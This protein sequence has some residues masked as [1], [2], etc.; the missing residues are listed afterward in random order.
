MVGALDDL[1][2]DLAKYTT[3]PA[4]TKDGLQWKLLAMFRTP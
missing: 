4:I 2:I 1:V 3:N